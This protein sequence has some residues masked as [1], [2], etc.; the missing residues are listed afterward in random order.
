MSQ[1]SFELEQLKGCCCHQQRWGGCGLAGFAGRVR[2]SALCPWPVGTPQ[3]LEREG[4]EKEV[5]EAEWR[6]CIKEQG[7]V[8]VLIAARSHMRQ[9]LSPDSWT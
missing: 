2:S 7:S 5:P 4:E 3:Q 1:G 6:K 9:R 8:T